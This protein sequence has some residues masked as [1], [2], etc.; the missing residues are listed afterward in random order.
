MANNEPRMTITI[1]RSIYE[2]LLDATDRSRPRLTKRY[3]VELALTRLLED[4]KRGEVE[5]GLEV[6]GVRRK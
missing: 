1:D 3:V 6:S 5:L 2:G 4:V